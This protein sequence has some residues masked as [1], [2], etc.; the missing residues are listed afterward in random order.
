M[1]DALR[2]STLQINSKVRKPGRVDKRSA[3][4]AEKTTEI[5]HEA[6]KSCV[7]LHGAKQSY[8][9]PTLLRGNDRRGGTAKKE[10]PEGMILL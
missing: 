8:L 5:L 2:L 10:N 6:K 9:V 7:I 1:V 4:T 3:S